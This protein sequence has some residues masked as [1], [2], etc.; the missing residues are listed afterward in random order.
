LKREQN[1]SGF[2]GLWLLQVIGEA[3]KMRLCRADM[4]FEKSCEEKQD[5][6]K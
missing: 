5:L 2:R 4:I 3:L 6:N 1:K